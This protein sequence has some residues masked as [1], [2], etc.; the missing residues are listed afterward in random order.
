MHATGLVRTQVAA[1][2]PPT[3]PTLP[4]TTREAR[5]RSTEVESPCRFSD[6]PGSHPPFGL[7]SGWWLTAAGLGPPWLPALVGTMLMFACL[8]ATF[9]TLPGFYAAAF[10]AAVL[11]DNISSRRKIFPRL[12]RFWLVRETILD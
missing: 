6:P 8:F 3:Q 12:G 9:V 5:L 4:T 2:S 1:V 10:P 7:V 11:R